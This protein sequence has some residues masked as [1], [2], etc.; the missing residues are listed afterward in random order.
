MPRLESA[1]SMRSCAGD[2]FRGEWPTTLQSRAR[3]SSPNTITAP[4][5][6]AVKSPPKRA[7]NSGTDARI[8][9]STSRMMMETISR[10]KP[11]PRE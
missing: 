4:I 2:F 7:S 8:I 1:Y 11:E 10:T 5:L 3:Y 9:A 6:M